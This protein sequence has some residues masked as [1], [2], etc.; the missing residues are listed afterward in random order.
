MDVWSHGRFNDSYKYILTVIDVFSNYL[1]MV[2]LKI[3]SGAAVASAF[4]FVLWD[5]RYRHRRRDPIWVRKDK[6]KNFW[7]VNFRP[8]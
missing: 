5:P 2:P 3:K 1:H 7:T 4:E 6:A 8:C